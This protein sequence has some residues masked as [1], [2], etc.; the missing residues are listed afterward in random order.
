M[1]RL[2]IEGEREID[3]Y[4]E[5][6]KRYLKKGGGIPKSRF[7]VGNCGTVIITP[8]ACI[9]RFPLSIT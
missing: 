5:R 2:S 6:E 3:I 1:L 9:S 4:I 7:F 8:Q